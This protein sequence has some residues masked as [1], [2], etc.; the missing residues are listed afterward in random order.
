M[1]E[2]GPRAGCE[3]SC[4]PPSL[5]DEVTAAN[6][7][8]AAMD[9]VKPPLRDPPVDLAIR[10]ALGSRLN[11]RERYGLRSS[12]G[13]SPGPGGQEPNQLSRAPSRVITVP[14]KKSPAGEA[15]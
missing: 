12:A 9:D 14:E 10:E 13:G 5:G 15:R 1:A 3:H 4:Q 8:H 11:S 7:V 6:R 2:N